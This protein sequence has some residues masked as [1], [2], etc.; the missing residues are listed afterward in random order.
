MSRPQS[1]TTSST[2]Q[3][4]SSTSVSSP[5]LV[6]SVAPPLVAAPPQSLSLSRPLLHTTL[7]VRE[8]DRAEVDAAVHCVTASFIASEDAW[9]KYCF[10]SKHGLKW[11]FSVMLD[12]CKRKGR[13]WIAVLQGKIVGVALWQPPSSA[14]GGVSM[15]SMMKSGLLAAPF[16]LGL[17]SCGKVHS[18]LMRTE[19]AH[20]TVM[21]KSP[22]HWSLYTIGVLQELRCGGIGTRLCEPVLNVADEERTPI[23]VDTASDRSVVFFR[24]M[25]FATLSRRAAESSGPAF[26]CC[27]RRPASERSAATAS[28]VLSSSSA[29]ASVMN[30]SVVS[31]GSSVGSNPMTSVALASSSVRA[32][33]RSND[34]DGSAVP[35]PARLAPQPPASADDDGAESEESCCSSGEDRSAANGALQRRHQLTDDAC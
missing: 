24:R 22:R 6:A 18:A 35:A 14:G 7:I 28:A 16:H 12:Y 2:T 30:S 15:L 9:I 19:A 4:T 33:E 3:A 13:L 21:S 32:T 5:A 10:D 1:A 17:A 25:G 26:W 31:S 34:G 23:Y 27:V 20:E 11:F 29:S 8:M